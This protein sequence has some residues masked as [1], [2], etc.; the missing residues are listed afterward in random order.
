[1]N[2]IVKIAALPIWSSPPVVERLSA[3]RTN[4]NFR[5]SCDDG[6]FFARAGI[7]IPF[8][9][10]RREHE[11]RNVRVASKAGLAPKLL[12]VVDG[13]QVSEFVAGKS[14]QQGE[15]VQDAT[16]IAVAE[17]LRS[18][19]ELSLPDDYHSYDMVRIARRQLGE[20]QP[21]TLGDTDLRMLHAVLDRAPP[22]IPQGLIHADLLP[23]NFIDDG[24]RHWL[25]DWEYGGRGDP[26]LDLANLSAGFL[27]N[28]EQEECLL[29]AYGPCDRKK[30]KAFGPLNQV[31]EAVWCLTQIQ[32]AGLHGD[33]GDYTQLCLSRL[34]ISS[35]C[36]P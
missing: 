5:V 30:V 17:L 22:Q 11:I 3:G 24:E 25:V 15:P 14:L 31:R 27:L 28:E 26:A 23:E 19:H 10:I 2:E 4:A 6:V 9:G 8:H 20:L 12:H 32:N 7:D 29:E 13:V 18:M 1:M 21:G 34:G 36:G 16:I 35:W 33:L